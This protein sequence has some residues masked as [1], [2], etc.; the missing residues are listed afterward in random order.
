MSRITSAKTSRNQLSQ[1]MKY[2]DWAGVDYNFDLGG[3]KYEK[4]TEWLLK[5]RNV[6]N[7][8]Y[9]PYNRSRDYNRLSLGMACLST[10]TTIFNVLCVIPE[11]EMRMKVL[12]FGKREKTKHIYI[13]V[14]HGDSSGI[15]KET[16]FGWQ[17]NRTLKSFLPE[18]Q[19]VYPQ[20]YI[21]RRMIIVDL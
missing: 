8:V 9:D 17:A 13:T 3:G 16:R 5:E 2:I 1:G 6:I 4:N 10:T 7:L 20:A 12:R 21:K 11:H 18:V 14:Y 15:G 19:E